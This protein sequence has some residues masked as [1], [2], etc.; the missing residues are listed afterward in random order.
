MNTISETMLAG[1]IS[2]HGKIASLVSGFSLGHNQFFSLFIVPKDTDEVLPIVMSVKLLEDEAYGNCPF[3][4]NCWTEP[5]VLK[6]AA[7]AIDLT[8]Y[9]VYWGC[10]TNAIEF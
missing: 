7:N 9:D 1:R 5:A 3:N 6:I 10:G 4:L 8:D 2:S